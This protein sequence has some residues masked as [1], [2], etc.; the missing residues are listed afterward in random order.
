MIKLLALLIAV[1]ALAVGCGS[2]QGAQTASL[3]DLGAST[4]SEP[5]AT[6]SEP[7]ATASEPIPDTTAPAETVSTP[8]ECEP[9]TG[10]S[11]GVFTNLVGVRVGAHD[12][13]DR[14]VFEFRAPN[15]NPGGKAGIPRYE[16]R[17]A[18]PPFTEDPSDMPIDVEG[19]AFVRL[20][21]HGATGYDFGGN[22]T[23]KGPSV[24]TPGFGTLAQVVEAGDF[25][26]TLSW[27]LG[28]SRPT[29]WVA[30]ELHNPD[31]LVLDFHHR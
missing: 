7:A 10:G 31:R 16:L 21:M 11:D 2:G 28:L 19:D 4:P 13:Y 18:K 30:Q 26:A 5:A 27:V 20:V 6:A 22:P 1:G 25:E 15:P 24:L 29:C 3:P 23:Y 9:R 12:G 8:V 14:I 17:T